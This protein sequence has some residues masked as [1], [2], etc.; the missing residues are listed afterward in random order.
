MKRF[1]STQLNIDFEKLK[2]YDNLTIYKS[3]VEELDYPYTIEVNDSSYFY[4]N[5]EDRNSDYEILYSELIFK[6]SLYDIKN[7]KVKRIKNLTPYEE[8][9]ILP[10]RTLTFAPEENSAICSQVDIQEGSILFEGCNIPLTSRKFANVENLPEFDP[11]TILIVS[12]K[13][14]NAMPERKDLVVPNGIIMDADGD[15]IGCK[16]FAID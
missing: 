13:V 2:S 3:Y 8:Y 4:A 1:D 15:I 7:A 14:K 12:R 11:N 5:E 16:S 9:L 10:E 6:I